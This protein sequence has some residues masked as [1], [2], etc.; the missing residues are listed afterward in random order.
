MIRPPRGDLV[1]AAVCGVVVV[2]VTADVLAGGLLTRLDEAISDR[3]P[4]SDD[5]P[6]WTHV[7]GLLGNAG[8]GGAAVRAAAIATMHALLRW[9]PGVMAFGQLVGSGLVVLALK[10][11]IDAPAVAHTA[12]SATRG[13]SP[14]RTSRRESLRG[15]ALFGLGR[16]P[17]VDGDD[18]LPNVRVRACWATQV[19]DQ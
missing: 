14:P 1:A 2:P 17:V 12:R 10:Y 15:C 11:A 5:A 9:W 7:V 18:S 6:T 16:G 4:S 13:R 3:L 8:V 19:E